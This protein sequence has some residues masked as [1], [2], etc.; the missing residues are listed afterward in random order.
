[1]RLSCLREIGWS[2]W[3]PIGLKAVRAGCDDE[4]DEYLLEAF[5]KLTLGDAVADVV[6]YLIQIE[7]EHIGLGSRASALSRATATSNALHVIVR[8]LAASA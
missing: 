4:Y 3:D 1:M 8:E 6:G 7:A 2:L 5:R